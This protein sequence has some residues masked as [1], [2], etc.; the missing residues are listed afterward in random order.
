[1]KYGE[2][3]KEIE[4][5]IANAIKEL[6]IGI[7]F[8]DYIEGGVFYHALASDVTWFIHSNFGLKSDF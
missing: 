5:I 2:C 4:K 3:E 7:N 8:D 1:M 6:E